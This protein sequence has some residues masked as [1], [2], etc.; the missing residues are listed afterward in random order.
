MKMTSI[1]RGH[2]RTLTGY[3]EVKDYLESKDACLHGIESFDEW[4]DIVRDA[5]TR[6]DVEC[7]VCGVVVPQTVKNIRLARSLSCLCNGR[8]A[9]SSE[10]GHQ[11]MVNMLD[12]STFEPLPVMLSYDWW[13]RNINT[14]RSH[15]PIRC[16]VC[17]YEPPRCQINTFQQSGGKSSCWCN[18][19]ARY[20]DE[21]GRQQILKVAMSTNYELAD[22]TLDPEKWIQHN[23]IGETR[24]TL[25][26]KSCGV[27]GQNTTV[28]SFMQRRSSS[29]SC[30]W[31]TQATV[32][33]FVR[34]RVPPGFS[35]LRKVSIVKPERGWP[36]RYDVAVQR[37]SDSRIILLIEVD[38]HQHF[39]R[40]SRF[41][42]SDEEQ[43]GIA[44]RDLA[45][46]NAAVE[47]GI[48]MLRLY[49]DDVW[50]DKV[51][52]KQL[53]S[54]HLYLAVEDE[55]PPRVYVQPDCVCYK[56]GIYAEMRGGKR[57]T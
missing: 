45:K 6:L 29:C 52:W 17:A 48:P 37:H 47:K 32:L 54:I 23:V 24:L 44:V 28:H 25:R 27:E 19:L 8:L 20:N 56:E 57:R 12:H 14:V 41:R 16:R 34:S 22:W 49:Q 30:K 55:L 33:E 9:W 31:K 35:T 2:W 40:V 1:A 4:L 10:A 51:D 5:G 7:N 15:V 13:K 11:R 3:K 39:E 38:G 18:G 42:L 53:I 43:Q 36:S 50:K 21:Q 26:C 46:E